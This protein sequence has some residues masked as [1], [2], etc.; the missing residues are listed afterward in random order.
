MATPITTL[1]QFL[2]SRRSQG[3]PAKYTKEEEEY[4]ISSTR[5]RLEKEMEDRKNRGLYIKK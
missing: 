2:E 3:F 5:K 1:E 4:Y